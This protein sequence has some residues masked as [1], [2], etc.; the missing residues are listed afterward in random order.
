MVRQSAVVALL[1]SGFLVACGG[2]SGGS[3]TQVLAPAPAPAPAPTPVPPAAPPP[4]TLTPSTLTLSHYAGQSKSVTLQAKQTVT[5]VGVAYLKVLVDAAVIDPNI[6]IMP[7][8]DATA[9]VTIKSLQSLQPGHYSGQLTVNVCSDPNCAAHLAGSP[10]KVPYEIDVKSTAGGLE[11]FNAAPLTAMAGATDWVTFQGNAGHT[12]YVPVTLNPAEFKARWKW[13]APATGTD[14]HQITASD[15]ATGGGRF[16]FSYGNTFSNKAESYLYAYNE[17]DGSQ[18]WKFPF[19]NEQYSNTNPPAYANGRVF[20]AGGSQS[21]TNMFGFDAAT[22]AQAFRT[23]MSS[24][25][26]NYLAPMVYNN[27]VY[28]DGGTYGGLY[29]FDANSGIRKYFANTAQWDGWSPATDGSYLYVYVAGQLMVLDMA[30]GNTIRKITDP[31]YSW[32]GYTVNFAP[33]VGSNGTVFAG[34]F[35]SYSD[36]AIT[37]F[38]TK[39]GTTRWS[40]K[41]AYSGN[42]GYADGLVLM[43]NNKT[44]QLEARSESD[45]KLMWSWDLPAI[46]NGF[47]GSVLLTKNMVFVSAT[48]NTYAINLGSRAQVWSY[49]A[50]GKLSLTASGTLLINGGGEIVAIGLH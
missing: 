7:N 34:N 4:Y 29:A 42:P 25:W 12:G 3:P 16:Y 40:I 23:A 28:T 38:D 19:S 13:S 30:T 46:E 48:S 22:G 15:I 20:M 32:N 17:A 5:F 27:V 14:Y 44:R 50:S 33:V 49:K 41:G 18:A 2:G 24:Q 45:G 10:F 37:A 39:A 8:A 1:L 36:N 9:S 35:N 47:V 43:T 6:E 26:E 31:S 21:N 11:V